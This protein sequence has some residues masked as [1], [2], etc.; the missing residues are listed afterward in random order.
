MAAKIWDSLVT[1]SFMSFG[2]SQFL[3]SI[4]KLKLKC[5]MR[6]D[7]T[8][9][10]KFYIENSCWRAISL[11]LFSRIE[12]EGMEEDGWW[13]E[14][15]VPGLCEKAPKYYCLSRQRDNV[16]IPDPLDAARKIKVPKLLRQVTIRELHNDSINPEPECMKAG[17]IYCEWY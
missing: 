8:F 12:E 15:E 1:V 16:T 13:F 9:V 14:I 6:Y 17:K 4:V 7:N 3:N 10:G 11:I 2:N 5:Y